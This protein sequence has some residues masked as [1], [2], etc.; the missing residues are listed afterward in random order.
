MTE[1]PF[2]TAEWRRLIMASFEVPA[3][4]LAAR[5]PPG[6][7]LD[8]WQGIACV[9]VV[10]F[11]FLDTRVWGFRI[12]AHRDFEEVNL[13]FY[14]RREHREGPRR[15]VVF[16]REIVPRRAI[17]LAAKLLYN[18]PYIT[19]PTRSSI[20]PARFAYGWRGP[21]GWSGLE[22]TVTGAPAAPAPD[23]LES[24]IA[25]QHWGYTAQADGGTLEYRVEH[26]RWAVWPG[27]AGGLTGDVGELAPGAL[28]DGLRGTPMSL[29][30]A[31]GSAVSVYRGQRLAAHRP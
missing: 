1:R 4:L 12:P 29:F 30:V 28:G 5:V 17:A 9:S 22:A 14:V 7:S 13:R 26:P 23:S 24:F 3:G 11:Q 21:G 25:E 10:A 19:R 31:E 15:G 20:E 27:A 2:L 8:L 16:I 18:E 6:T